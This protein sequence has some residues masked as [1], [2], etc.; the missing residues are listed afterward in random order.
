MTK[1]RN[2]K[3]GKIVDVKS[4][5]VETVTEIFFIFDEA[6]DQVETVAD[7][8]FKKEYELLTKTEEK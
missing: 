6:G 3:T 4:M 1:Y 5:E 8:A 2:K 7:W